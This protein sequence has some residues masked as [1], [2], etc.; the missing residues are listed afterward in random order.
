MKGKAMSLRS[1]GMGLL[2]LSASLLM[3]GCPSSNSPSSASSNPPPPPPT[4]TSTPNATATAEAQIVATH[5][6]KAT[7][8]AQVDATQA[9]RASET[10]TGQ[11]TATPT[12]SVTSTPTQTATPYPTTAWSLYSTLGQQAG[13]ANPPGSNGYFQSPMGV[14]VGDGYLA[15]SDNEQQ[16]VQVFNSTGGYLYTVTPHGSYP[17]LWGMAI[18]ASGELY[19]ADLGD[20]EV[21]GYVLGS[22]GYAYDYTW[23]AQGQMGGPF[24][25]KID[26]QGNLVVADSIGGT[27]WNLA[28]VDDSVLN[29]TTVGPGTGLQPFDV[30]LDASGNLYVSDTN[31]NSIDEYNNQYVYTGFSFNGSSWTNPL[32]VPYSVGVDSQGNLFISDPEN[33]TPRVV[34]TDV[35]GDYL[36]EIDGFSYPTFLVL[37]AGDDLFVTDHESFQVDEYMR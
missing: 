36:G 14:A 37:D 21:D 8:T 26:S 19:V 33:G 18:D 20:E 30:A 29:Q 7:A 31:N 11:P 23:T 28:W 5:V 12:T 1:L 16:D 9:L 27:V 17:D 24:G 13:G 6:A 32:D 2:F 3:T 22:S 15:V 25:V 34:Y 4:V 35:Q 10:A